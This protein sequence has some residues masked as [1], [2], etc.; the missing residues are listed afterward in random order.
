MSVRVNVRR[1]R[2]PLVRLRRC[3][4]W[5]CQEWEPKRLPLAPLVHRRL[6]HYSHN[7]GDKWFSHNSKVR[8][9][10]RPLRKSAVSKRFR[11][12]PRQHKDAHSKPLGVQHQHR[13]VHCFLQQPAPT[14]QLPLVHR[15]VRAQDQPLLAYQF[16]HRTSITPSRN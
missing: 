5:R 11:L 14:N 16:H 1:K 2:C 9:M 13:Q 4:D 7:S 15:L 3:Q 12:V 10:V 6:M 8:R